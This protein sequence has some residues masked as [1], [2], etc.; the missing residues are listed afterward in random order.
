[1]NNERTLYKVIFKNNNNARVETSEIEA[2]SLTELEE[3]ANQ[4]ATELLGDFREIQ[5][6]A[7][8]IVKIGKVSR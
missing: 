1:M 6:E 2:Q 4:I 8:A 7:S 3:K 5:W